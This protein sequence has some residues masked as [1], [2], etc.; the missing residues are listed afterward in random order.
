M[1]NLYEPTLLSTSAERMLNAFLSSYN[2]SV[3]AA[4]PS[5][6]VPAVNVTVVEGDTAVLEC[7]ILHLTED[8]QVE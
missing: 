2:F 1:P 6:G 7:S 4:E 5:F 3:F 8:H